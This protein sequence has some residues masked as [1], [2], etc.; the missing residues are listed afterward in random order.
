MTRTDREAGPL[1]GRRQ[2][3]TGEWLAS[4]GHTTGPA[5]EGWGAN[6]PARAGQPPAA[7]RGGRALRMAGQS[8]PGSPACADH[9]SGCVIF[10]GVLYNRAELR[11][12][13]ADPP[14]PA[15]DDA[16]LVLHAYRRWGEDVLRRIKG[17]FT[18]LV[19]DK[20]Q[21][22]LLCARD[23]LGVYPLFYAGAGQEV[24]VST[25]IPAILAHPGISG[26]LNPVLLAD[27]LAHRW[28]NP[29]KLTHSPSL[30]P[31]SP[32]TQS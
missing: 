15:V 30:C 8:G 3:G 6:G 31:R 9:P 1:A 13:L 11:A 18:L 5:P 24:L 21:D 27:H 29:A 25:S 23:P 17:I 12:G 16:T 19:F 22:T 14:H 7:G 26:E 20:D 10:D 2:L 4:W 28:P 32:E